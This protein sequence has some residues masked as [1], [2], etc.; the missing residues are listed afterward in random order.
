[1]QCS[2]VIFPVYGLWASILLNGL[3]LC[4]SLFS[5]LEYITNSICKK[6]TE[7]YNL[8]VRFKM[9]DSRFKN[10][11]VIPLYSSCVM[12]RLFVVWYEK[13]FPTRVDHHVCPCSRRTKGIF[14]WGQSDMWWWHVGETWNPKLRWLGIFLF[15]RKAYGQSTFTFFHS[16]NENHHGF[17]L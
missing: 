8:D 2:H 13:T 1:M 7:M 6:K 11:L 16:I 10:W 5:L 14:S 4:T 3:V 15:W 9:Q 17:C 12:N